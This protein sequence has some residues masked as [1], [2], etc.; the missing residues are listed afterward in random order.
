MHTFRAPISGRNFSRNSLISIVKTGLHGA[1]ILRKITFGKE[2]VKA[3]L[4]TRV[5]VTVLVMLLSRS[6]VWAM[7]AGMMSAAALPFVIAI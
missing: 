3:R 1:S 7:F 4:R 2:N 6:V 5:A